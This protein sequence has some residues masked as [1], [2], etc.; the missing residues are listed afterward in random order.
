MEMQE[1][2][3]IK[4]LKLT[5]LFLFMLLVVL[6]NLPNIAVPRAIGI[7]LTSVFAIGIICLLIKNLFDLIFY[8]KL[9]FLKKVFYMSSIFLLICTGV[10][11]GHIR[12]NQQINS[13]NLYSVFIVN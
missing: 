10:T 6:L 5:F 2:K 4:W 3:I 13:F 7:F 9:Q 1:E 11:G 12:S 8:S